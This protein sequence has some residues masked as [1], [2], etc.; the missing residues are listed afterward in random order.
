MTILALDGEIIPMKSPRINLAM[1]LKEQDMSG[2]SSGTNGSEQGDKGMMLTVSGLIPFKQPSV[3]K[4]LMVLSRQKEECKRKIYRI[5]NE[6]AQ[7]MT[8]RQVRFVGRVTADE[9]ESLMAWKVSF[10]L[11]EYLSVSEV[12]EQR[13]E[14]KQGDEQTETTENTTPAEPKAHAAVTNSE[15][16]KQQTQFEEALKRTEEALTCG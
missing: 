14:E 3:L 1:E 6:L 7:A 12:K 11:R 5:G 9:Q 13:E 8:I 4:R 15:E 16:T 2:Q 10:Q